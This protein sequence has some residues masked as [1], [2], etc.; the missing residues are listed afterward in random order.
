MAKLLKVIREKLDNNPR[1]KPYLLM[2][3]RKTTKTI[4]KWPQDKFIKG[5]MDCY[6]RHMG[7]R[8]DIRQPVLF[9]EKLQ[10]YKVFY[11]RDD[12]ANITDK[13]LFKQYVKERIGDGFTIPCF[14]CWSNVKDLAKD[15]D[16]LPNE[17]VLKANLQ[18]NSLN[19]KIIHD[20]SKIDFKTIKDELKSWLNI[21]NTQLNS[22][23]WHF[24]NGTPKILAEKYMSNFEDQLFDYNRTKL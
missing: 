24:Y 10:W 17:F 23:D 13:F 9:T 12:F 19:I 15:W 16:S 4:N 22:W 1:L 20:K 11:K 18:S 21:R 8:F 2:W 5:V 3:L 7:Y 6:E 14:G